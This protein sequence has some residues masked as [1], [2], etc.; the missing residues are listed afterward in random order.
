MRCP[1]SLEF[2]SSGLWHPPMS[3]TCPFSAQPPSSGLPSLRDRRR[4]ILPGHK[5]AWALWK[6]TTKV[7]WSNKKRLRRQTVEKE[8]GLMWIR[9]RTL[10][11][12][13]SF[14]WKPLT[15]QISLCLFVSLSFYILPL[16]P[17]Q[18]RKSRRISP[19]RLHSWKAWA[20]LSQYYCNNIYH[21][22]FGKEEAQEAGPGRRQKTWELLWFNLFFFVLFLKIH[23]AKIYGLQ[24]SEK[25]SS[26]ETPSAVN[27]KNYINHSKF[28][29]K[30]HCQPQRRK[31]LFHHALAMLRDPL[32][33]LPCLPALEGTWWH[34]GWALLRGWKLL[35]DI[36]YLTLLKALSFY[37]IPSLYLYLSFLYF[38]NLDLGSC[39][40]LGSIRSEFH[41]VWNFSQF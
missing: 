17:P 6:L 39:W 41:S 4:Y 22:N 7:L 24:V 36:N 1:N 40:F 21:I 10:C 11:L 2:Q 16:Q 19:W 9:S 28:S 26:K 15:S 25:G 35:E 32:S 18:R 34:V 27:E 20:F 31:M 8:E 33:W 38:L 37:R 12:L 14:S 5:G 13:A 23:F 29:M 30:L 3:L